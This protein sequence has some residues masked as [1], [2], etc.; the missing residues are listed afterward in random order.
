[1]EKQNQEQWWSFYL[2]RYAQGTVF[3]AVIVFFLFSQ[4]QALKPLLFIP[5]DGNGFGISHLILLG[6]Y[7]LA[8]CYISSAPILV[9]HAARAFLFKEKR[10]DKTSK[11]CKII[12]LITLAGAAATLIAPI[13]NERAD[14]YKFFAA[15]LYLFIIFMQFSALINIKSN[16][17][18]II[19]YYNV[20]TK[21]RECNAEYVE[22]YRHIRE[23]ANSFLIIIFQLALAIPIHAFTYNL[24]GVEGIIK[25]IYFIFLF[26]VIPPA[27]IWI[28][29]HGLEYQLIKSKNIK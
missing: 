11:P 10:T 5:N 9:L 26:W 15:S 3:G 7:G 28:F 12:I 25:N 14:L 1:M 6:I 19:N 13:G 17:T 27:C 18:D 20:V 8:Y 16:W 22:S 4:N 21:A 29:G 2:V 24:I 23:H